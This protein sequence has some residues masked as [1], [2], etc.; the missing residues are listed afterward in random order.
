M[1]LIIF[2]SYKLLPFF[3]KIE[4]IESHSHSFLKSSFYFDECDKNCLNLKWAWVKIHSCSSKSKGE[5]KCI[6]SMSL[7]NR[8]VAILT[9]T[10]KT[11]K[12]GY[13]I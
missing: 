1:G 3:L 2:F 7:E 6:D 10:K 11:M 13:L 4:H 5:I 12:D 9:G 8:V